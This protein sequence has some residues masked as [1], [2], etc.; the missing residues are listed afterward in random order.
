MITKNPKH[1]AKVTVVG[2][3]EFYLWGMIPKY[4]TVYLDHE[5]KSRTRIEF[6]NISIEE[7]HSFSDLMATF[8]SFG[9]YSPKSYKI[10]AQVLQV[11][12]D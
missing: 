12:D 1:K 10:S 2:H 7:Y 3:K 8:F 9:I 5:L 6:S 4:H 11:E